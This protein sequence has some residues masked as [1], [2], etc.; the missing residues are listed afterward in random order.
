MNPTLNNNDKMLVSGLLYK[1]SVGE[2][3][4]F[5]KDEYDPDKALVKRVIAVEGQEINMD[6]EKYILYLNDNYQFDPYYILKYFFD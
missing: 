1:P 6:F 4:V 5:K 3:V 2:V